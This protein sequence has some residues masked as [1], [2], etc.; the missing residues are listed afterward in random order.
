[1][2]LT[3]MLANLVLDLKMTLDTEIS[4]AEATRCINR[5]VDDLSRKIPRERIYEHTWVEA[6]TDDSFTTPEATDTTKIVA[7][8]GLID[9]VDG[10]VLTLTTTWMD[11][12]RP[13][14]ITLTDPAS[15]GSLDSILRM[16]LIVKGTD[17]DGVYREERFYR[18][19]G[20]LQTGKVYFSSI[21][22]VEVNELYGSDT[23]DTLSV[24]TTSGFGIWVQ[25][26]NPIKP[27][28]ET[29]YSA[30]SKGGTLYV[31]DTDYQ[32]DYAN[33]RILILSVGSM[34]E[35]TT[36]YANY[37]KAQCTIDIS[38]IV[39]ELIRIVKVIYPV[40]KIPEQSVAFT[41]W[42]DMLTIGSPRPTV[43]QE[44][45]TD[46]EHIAIYYEARHA[47]PTDV[48]SGSY[49]ELLDQVVLIGAAAYALLVE[50]LQYELQAVTDLAEVRTT[51][52][53]LGT[54]GASPTLIYKLLDDALD[55]VALYLET[56]NT[57]DNA[58]TMLEKITDDITLLR[59]AIRATG[60][61][62][63]GALAEAAIA[64][65]ETSS[66]DLDA[67]TVGAVAWLL[68]GELKI[69]TLTDGERVAEKF[70]DY[71]RVKVQIAQ[72]RVQVAMAYAQEAQITLDNLRSYIDE[73]GGWMRMGEDFMAEAQAR[74][75][76]IDRYLAEAGQYQEVIA[77]DL[78]LS[79]RFRAEGQIRMAEFQRILDSKA[80][81]RKRVTSV[82]VRQPA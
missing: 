60:T 17:A 80:E 10:D 58:V 4:T 56:Y 38:T 39:P 5:A 46:K 75:G 57:S 52:D 67:G 49:P 24:G 2:D 82:S 51:L 50:A 74:M 36:Y 61:P 53:Y 7:A 35:N 30:A 25:L 73:A 40:D 54:G 71:A 23:N 59:N 12:P 41:V 6:V 16:T 21:Y 43:S 45:M 29:I 77:H 70:A 79:D 14:Y 78:L 3:E 31:R 63:T 48:G 66:I 20:K 19:G 33:G 68:E 22:E 27:E 15:G 69:D 34:L 72:T 44:A 28:S 1:M 42:E 64:L 18:H 47:P 9:T 55:K 8:A 81:Y 13:V 62:M 76:E 32:M 11:V 26:D 65:G 37:D